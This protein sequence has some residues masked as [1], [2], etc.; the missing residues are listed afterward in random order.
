M[1]GGVKMPGRKSKQQK[2]LDEALKQKKFEQKRIEE[3]LKSLGKYT[4]AL[5]PLI[6]MYLDVCEVYQI[7]Y[8]EWKEGGFKSTKM[9]TN[10]NGSKN[11]IKHPLAQQ[12]EVW[13]DKKTKLLNQLG[14]DTKNGGLEYVDPL[15]SEKQNQKEE[16]PEPN[17][18]LLKFR[19]M[20]GGQ[21]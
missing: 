13:C 14:L 2:I 4:P 20:R 15:L 11:E 12:V 21:L 16:P 19:N 9:H 18:K 17:N 7:K 8:L 10:K 1:K 5:N 6:E 3:I